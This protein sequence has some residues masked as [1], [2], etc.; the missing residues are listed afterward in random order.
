MQDKNSRTVNVVTKTPLNIV[1]TRLQQLDKEQAKT[2]IKHFFQDRH[3][4]H[5]L[6]KINNKTETPS[7]ITKTVHRKLFATDSKASNSTS[8]LSSHLKSRLAGGARR[9]LGFLKKACSSTSLNKCGSSRIP[10]P[11]SIPKKQ[12]QQTPSNLVINKVQTENELFKQVSNILDQTENFLNEDKIVELPIQALKM[13]FQ[14]PKFLKTVNRVSIIEHRIETPKIEVEP[15]EEEE[16][17][18]KMLD[19]KTKKYKRN[20]KIIAAQSVIRRSIKI[21][22]SRK[23][24]STL[25]RKYHQNV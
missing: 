6:T 10:V 9:S 11:V 13:L 20:S 22:T 21:L 19:L 16:K 2:P 5:S 24:A 23:P 4:S 1:N 14:T 25:Q 15:E 7:T 12:Q 3:I 8:K 17:K 18:E